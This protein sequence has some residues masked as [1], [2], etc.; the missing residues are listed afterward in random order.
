MRLRTLNE[1]AEL[2]GIS[3]RKLRDGIRRGIYPC[4]EWKS[5]ILVD[6]DVIQ[7][8]I[9]E[10]RAGARDDEI[11]LRAC[12]AAIGVSEN[13]MRNMAL[14]GLV[15]YRKQGRYYRFVLEAVEAAIQEHMKGGQST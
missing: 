12:A 13:T 10:E 15:P 7:A 5:R 9:D 6:I 3:R 8:I 4:V 11:G 1:A 14:A 2:L